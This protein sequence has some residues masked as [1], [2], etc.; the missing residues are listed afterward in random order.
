MAMNLT[1]NRVSPRLDRFRA[2][3]PTL[4]KLG[5]TAVATGALLATQPLLLGDRYQTQDFGYLPSLL[6]GATLGFGK[7]NARMGIA[8]LVAPMIGYFGYTFPLLYKVLEKL[9]FSQPKADQIRTVA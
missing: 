7:L 5:K 8:A 4:W 1:L 2:N 3:H 9:A 6:M